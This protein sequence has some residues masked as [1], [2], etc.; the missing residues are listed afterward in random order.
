MDQEAALIELNLGTAD[1]ARKLKKLLD[2]A[3]KSVEPILAFRVASAILQFLYG[4]YQVV[5]IEW[6][7]DYDHPVLRDDAG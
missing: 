5:R 4:P 1:A 2:N 6:L 3:L 7:L